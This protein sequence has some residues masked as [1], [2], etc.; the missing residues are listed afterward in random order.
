MN[1]H[2]PNQTQPF[3]GALSECG[4]L[5]R[6]NQFHEAEKLKARQAQEAAQCGG[7][8]NQA[9]PAQV[10]THT[11]ADEML[12]HLTAVEHVARVMAAL[13]YGGSAAVQP[14]DQ[15]QPGAEELRPVESLDSKVSQ[16]CDRLER[17]A[18]FMHDVAG[19]LGRY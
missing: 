3:G 9:M 2:Y 1:H 17:L 16:A 8:A 14:F 19:K 18:G 5:G 13:L 7:L 10:N 12:G 6:S 15:D 4:Q 11:K